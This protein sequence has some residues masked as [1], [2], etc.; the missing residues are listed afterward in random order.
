MSQNESPQSL[1]THSLRFELWRKTWSR[2]SSAVP[3]DW[4]KSHMSISCPGD[5]SGALPLSCTLSPVHISLANLHGKAHC[6]KSLPHR[7][8]CGNHEERM[9]PTSMIAWGFRM[10]ALSNS[11]LVVGIALAKSSLLSE[12]ENGRPQCCKVPGEP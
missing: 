12:R 7:L 4:S 8:A 1:M 5:G 6:W 2:P 3:V 10:T 11:T 9:A